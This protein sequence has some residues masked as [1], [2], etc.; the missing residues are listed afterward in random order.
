MILRSPWRRMN[1]WRYFFEEQGIGLK[2][3]HQKEEAWIMNYEE[4]SMFLN[5]SIQIEA[6]FKRFETATERAA[7]CMMRARTCKSTDIPEM[8]LA[9]PQRVGSAYSLAK[10]AAASPGTSHVAR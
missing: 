4:P 10:N 5:P 7:V 1:E 8:Q 2:D 9:E 6:N 3:M